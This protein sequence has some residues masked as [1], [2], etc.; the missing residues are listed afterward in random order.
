MLSLK[1][2]PHFEISRRTYGEVD[3]SLCISSVK[4]MNKST[5]DPV[6]KHLS[7]DATVIHGKSFASLGVSHSQCI[8]K[9]TFT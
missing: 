4:K 2:Y 5:Q 9:S 8:I 3:C 6:S 1:C 7:L